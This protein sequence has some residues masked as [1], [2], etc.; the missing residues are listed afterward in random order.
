[1]AFWPRHQSKS[2]LRKLREKI[3]VKQAAALARRE[4]A[5]TAKRQGKTI[6]SHAQPFKTVLQM[7]GDTRLISLQL[8]ATFDEYPAPAWAARRHQVRLVSGVADRGVSACGCP[9]SCVPQQRKRFGFEN[10]ERT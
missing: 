1:M 6:A 4:F 2:T 5:G 9:T 3:A 8:R 7:D 10:I